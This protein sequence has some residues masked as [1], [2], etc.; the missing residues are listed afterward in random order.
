MPFPY[1][2]FTHDFV[3]RHNS[4]TI[5]KFADDMTVVGLITDDDETAYREEVSDLAVW[6]QNNNLSLKRQQEK[7]ADRGLQETGA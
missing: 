3:A 4:H 6:C 1:S 2:L 5:I 7:G